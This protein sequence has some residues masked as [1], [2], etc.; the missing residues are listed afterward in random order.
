[1]SIRGPKNGEMIS[2]P[3]GSRTGKRSTGTTANPAHEPSRVLPQAD[4]SRVRTVISDRDAA[5]PS[6]KSV[7]NLIADLAR[8]KIRRSL[9]LRQAGALERGQCPGAHPPQEPGVGG[10]RQGVNTVAGA[11]FGLPPVPPGCQRCRVGQ[12][13]AV[14]GV[15]VHVGDDRVAV[16]EERD[17][18]A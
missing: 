17:G 5:L 15:V 2:H 7:C 13:G 16:L 10:T 1:M 18:A 8:T 14:E 9:G 6:L 11:G 4:G 12:L 3:C